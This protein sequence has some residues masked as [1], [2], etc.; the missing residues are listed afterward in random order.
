MSTLPAAA[1]AVTIEKVPYQGWPNCYRVTNG[2]VELIVTSDIGPRIMRFGFVGGKNLFKEYEDQLGGTGEAE[3]K[4]RG[5]HR[6]WSAPEDAK[7]TY[8]LDNSAARIEVA[9]DQLIATSMAEPA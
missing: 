9:G 4:L 7:R 3:W 8:A 2:E 6:I 5:G 1:S